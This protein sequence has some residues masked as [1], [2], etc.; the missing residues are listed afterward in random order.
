MVF[1]REMVFIISSLRSNVFISRLHTY[2]IRLNTTHFGK[3]LE[4]NLKNILKLIIFLSNKKRVE[5]EK[6]I[7]RKQSVSTYFCMCRRCPLRPFGSSHSTPLLGSST[8]NYSFIL[9]LE[10]IGL[11]FN[12]AILPHFGHFMLTKQQPLFG[13]A[14]NIRL[15]HTGQLI[16]YTIISHPFLTNKT[17]LLTIIL[18]YVNIIAK[19][20]S[21]M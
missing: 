10:F 1:C 6:W 11:S 3:H 19:E 21:F 15:L 12:F 2:I 4:N 9:L 7:R 18:I 20:I 17:K 16:L 14:S 5:C 8:L 13:I